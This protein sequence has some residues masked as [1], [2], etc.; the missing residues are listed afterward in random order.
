MCQ[1]WG[2]VSAFLASGFPPADGS[3]SD[4]LIRRDGSRRINRSKC[5][6]GGM[7]N[8]CRRGAGRRVGDR[9]GLRD[10]VRVGRIGHGRRSDQGGCQQH[11]QKDCL[12]QRPGLV[13]IAFER[14]GFSGFLVV[15]A[16][17]GQ[18]LSGLNGC[19]LFAVSLPAHLRRSDPET[20]DEPADG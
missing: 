9:F 18:V 10:T 12:Q 6:L 3:P 17:H 16:C 8:A 2:R 11:A 5:R 7:A 1:T 20:D 14:S 19:T 15:D 4:I 13:Q